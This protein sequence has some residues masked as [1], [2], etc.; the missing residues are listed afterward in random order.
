MVVRRSWVLAAASLIAVVLVAF[1]YWLWRPVPQLNSYLPTNSHLIIGFGSDYLHGNLTDIGQIPL[2]SSRQELLNY[3]TDLSSI[4]FSEVDA[5]VWAITDD[6]SDQTLLLNLKHGL[7][8]NQ[9]EEI[10]SRVIGKLALASQSAWRQVMFVGS[11]VII[12]SSDNY[13]R[14]AKINVL[15]SQLPDASAYLLWDRVW[16]KSLTIAN[17]DF[18]GQQSTGQVQFDNKNNLRRLIVR[19]PL[20]E[21]SAQKTITLPLTDNFELY[22]DGRTEELAQLKDFS[23]LRPWYSTLE[24]HLGQRYGLALE[25]V[26]KSFGNNITF[27]LKQDSWLVQSS[28]SSLQQV[29]SSMSGYLSP[30]VKRGSL[31]DGSAYRELVRS[32]GQSSTTTIAGQPILV[33]TAGPDQ[34]LYQFDQPERST[35]SND[36]DLLA[37]I[38]SSKEARGSWQACLPPEKVDW[39]SIAWL[40]SSLE[41]GTS[42][43]FALPSPWKS[44]GVLSGYTESFQ[45]YVFC[46]L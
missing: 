33:W 4:E 5:A 23:V 22:L 7:A 43:I 6:L 25:T 46:L 21:K 16:P 32:E 10:R 34:L 8:K 38:I 12:T 26:L 24:Q 1:G 35:I 30:M 11:V 27:L 20:T 14:P 42:T 29:A 19:L 40:Q 3:L 31:P 44:A 9:Q 13:Q 36:Q 2:A 37:S 41:Q 17:F 18:L 28:T 15:A 45:E 39:T